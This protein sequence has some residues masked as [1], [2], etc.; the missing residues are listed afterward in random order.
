MNLEIHPN[1]LAPYKALLSDF[2][3][4]YNRM[5]E[6]TTLTHIRRVYDVLSTNNTAYAVS[7][8]LE[9]VTLNR[10]LNEHAG[11]LNWDQAKTMFDPLFE[12]LAMIHRSGYLH[13]AI[14]PENIMVTHEGMLVLI[15]FT[16]CSANVANSEIVPNLAEGYASPEQYVVQQHGEWTDV[17]G[18]CAVLYRVLTGTRPPHA[19]TRK[20]NDALVAPDHLNPNVP[21][22]VSDAVMAGMRYHYQDRLQNCAAL[23]DALFYGIMEQ[24]SAR[25]GASIGE[26][27]PLYAHTTKTKVPQDTAMTA[28]ID[29]PPERKS[30]AAAPISREEDEEYEDE[31]RPRRRQPA[32]GKGKKSKKKK[33]PTWS[34]ILLI[35]VPIVILLTLLLYQLM[36][37]F[38][39]NPNKNTS[40]VSST[41][42]EVVSST[43][44]EESSQ[45][46]PSAAESKVATYPMVNF[47]GKEYDEINFGQYASFRFDNP[48]YEYNDSYEEGMVFRQSIEEGTQV[49]EG[50]SVVLYVSSG[51]R[52]ITLPGTQ[53]YTASQY[54]DLLLNK[55]DIVT[56]IEKE[57]DDTIQPGKITRVSP[58]EGSIYDRQ[59]KTPVVIYQ[60]IGPDPT[61]EPE[62]STEENSEEEIPEEVP[63]E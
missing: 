28:L 25:S 49:E 48:K 37:G 9:A 63:V 19:Q 17:Y 44:G 14:C 12:E 20:A 39:K 42:S 56:E 38:G 5:M 24:D 15:S 54:A 32:K 41:L 59:S 2:N 10:Y 60:S 13:R 51:A 36:I 46:E 40:A 6:W 50:T 53:D 26:T 47:V 11:D 61:I 16:I 45:A 22:Y 58:S 43:S 35:S 29:T 31:D 8:Y 1:Y 62:E 34:K 21:K 52:S 57:Y 18:L 33:R 55:Y 3:D 27:A 4:L 30:R 23:R 7:E